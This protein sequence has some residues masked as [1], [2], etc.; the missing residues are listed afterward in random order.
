MKAKATRSVKWNC[1]DELYLLEKGKE[2][3]I[4]KQDLEQARASDLFEDFK[5]VVKPIK[6]TKA[7]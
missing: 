3:S 1:N 5:E 4:R 7:K 6:T 2:F